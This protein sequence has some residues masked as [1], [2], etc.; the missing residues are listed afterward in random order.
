MSPAFAEGDKWPI[1]HVCPDEYGHLDF[2]VSYH[3][4]MLVEHACFLCKAQIK[5]TW[6]GVAGFNFHVRNTVAFPFSM[7]ESIYRSK[8][9]HGQRVFLFLYFL[10]I[11]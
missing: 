5:P 10:G 4:N 6:T 2:P 9:S 8:T 11:V 3:Q 1:L 7:V